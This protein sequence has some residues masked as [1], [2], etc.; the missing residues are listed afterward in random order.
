M[1]YFYGYAIL[2]AQLELFL[3]MQMKTFA[4]SEETKKII[5]ERAEQRAKQ[6]AENEKR[7]ASACCYYSVSLLA[8]FKEALGLISQLNGLFFPTLKNTIARLF[9]PLRD[10]IPKIIFNSTNTY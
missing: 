1:L 7:Y 10:F 6:N 9:W 3:K 5:K 8:S 2:E 4:Y